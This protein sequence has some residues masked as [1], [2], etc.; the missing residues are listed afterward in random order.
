MAST[1][2]AEAAPPRAPRAFPIAPMVSLGIPTLVLVLF[3]VLPIIV[4]MVTKRL[5]LSLQRA[6]RDMVLHGE[7]TGRIQRTPE[8]RFYE[9]HADLDAH[10]RWA[11][12]QHEAHRPL[13]LTAGED[14]DEYGVRTPRGLAYG[15]RSKLSDF[16]FKDRVEPISP[17]ELA[18]AHHHGEHDALPGGTAVAVEESVDHAEETAS[19]RS[20]ERH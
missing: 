15:L 17:A 2:A 9:V 20:D 11:L 8:G 18:A 10:D 16:Y 13:S 6:D 4:F 7:E 1:I 19:L 3:F 5:C 12:V 14:T